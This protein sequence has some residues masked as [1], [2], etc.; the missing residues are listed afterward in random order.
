M[1]QLLGGSISLSVYRGLHFLLTALQWDRQT[2]V[3]ANVKELLTQLAKHAHVSINTRKSQKGQPEG[4]RAREK[5][6]QSKEPHT[7]SL[8]L[9]LPP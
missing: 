1:A 4:P 7:P 8:F 3:D 6:R 2:D 9:Q 5:Y